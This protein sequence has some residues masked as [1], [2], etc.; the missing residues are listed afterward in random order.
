MGKRR[1]RRHAT[2]PR[3][4]AAGHGPRHRAG[5]L[6]GVH[7]AGH[8][9]PAPGRLRAAR[10]R[11]PRLAGLAN[12][13][14]TPTA[15]SAPRGT[16][17]EHRRT[18]PSRKVPVPLA[19]ADKRSHRLPRLAQAPRR[20]P[21]G[22]GSRP[23]ETWNTVWGYSFVM[24]KLALDRRQNANH[25]VL[26]DEPGQHVAYLLPGGERRFVPWLGFIERAEARA[27]PGARPVRLADI[28]RIGGRRP[29][30][31]ALA[32]GVAGALR[33]RLPDRRGGLCRLRCHR[34]RGAGTQDL[35]PGPPFQSP[36]PV[37]PGGSPLSRFGHVPGRPF[38]GASLHKIRV[39]RDTRLRDNGL[40]AAA[41]ALQRAVL[42]TA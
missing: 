3:P 4:A 24:P 15:L 20:M 8:C 34:R 2:R 10:G 5:P 22:D 39:S 32:R 36:A 11:G 21:A 33:P 6:R 42:P 28:T 25:H 30:H 14:S 38:P 26:V 35:G 7:L 1:Q 27:L 12:A 31:G 9:P 17:R 13:S 40:F 19:A 18:P 41:R 29:A 23:G 37:H 16:P